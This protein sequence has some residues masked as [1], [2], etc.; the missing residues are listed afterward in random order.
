MDLMRLAKRQDLRPSRSGEIVISREVFHDFKD[1]FANRH[2]F[3]GLYIV[4]A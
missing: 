1:F 4:D 3:G 2:C